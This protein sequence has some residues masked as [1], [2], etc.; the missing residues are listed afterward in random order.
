MTGRPGIGGLGDGADA[1]RPSLRWDAGTYHD[2]GVAA[3]RRRALLARQQ[4]GL[5]DGH[6]DSWRGSCPASRQADPGRGRDAAHDGALH[7][8]PA[9]AIYGWEQTPDQSTTDRLPHR[10][11]VEGLW[12]SG[13]WTQ[14]GGGVLTVMASALQTVEL[15]TGRPVFARPAPGASTGRRSQMNRHCPAPSSPR[16]AGCGAPSSEAGC[17]STAPLQLCLSDRCRSRSRTFPGGEL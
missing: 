11:P 12:L 17:I 4:A 6:V 9:R 1:D 14:P 2:D 8:E 10:T 5:P 15:V 16:R 3:I 13:H 7:A